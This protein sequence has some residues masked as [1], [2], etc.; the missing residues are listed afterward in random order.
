MF[1]I[2]TALSYVLP[3]KNHFYIGFIGLLTSFAISA[4]VW[5]VLIFFSVTERFEERW[6]EKIEL[7][8]GPVRIV[9]TEQY[10]KLPENQIDRLSS[11]KGYKTLRLN[12]SQLFEWDPLFDA[13]L[14][15]KE[16]ESLYTEITTGKSKRAVTQ[17][18]DALEK[19][20]ALIVGSETGVFDVSFSTEEENGQIRNASQYMLTIGRSLFF[21]PTDSLKTIW[22]AQ[23]LE[24]FMQMLLKVP[25]G[26]KKASEEL[27][28][29]FDASPILFSSKN[30]KSASLYTIAIEKS[31]PCIREQS[32]DS[33]T[34][35]IK[36]FISS[37]GIGEIIPQTKN[38]PMTSLPLE[39][40]PGVGY[41]VYL[42]QQMKAHGIELF[43]TGVL[44]QS[45]TNEKNGL[46]I[47]VMGF[48]DTGVLSIGGK[49]A[50]LSSQLVTSL[51]SSLPKS[52]DPF[53]SSSLTIFPSLNKPFDAQQA[54]QYAKN[55]LHLLPQNLQ[56]CFLIENYKEYKM[57]QELFTQL[58]SEKNLFR[59]IAIILL[60]AASTNIFS[61]L[62]ILVHTKTKEI[63]IMRALGASKKSIQAIF[64]FSGLFIGICGALVG[65]ILASITLMLLPEIM[66][67]L[68]ML[69]GHEVLQ[70]TIYGQM[71]RMTL[72]WTVFF[73]CIGV[74]GATSA[75]AGFLASLKALKLHISDSLRAG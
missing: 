74:T 40:I 71:E 48:F 60:S 62:F 2:S 57:T 45:A 32:P 27:L 17:L 21:L 14:Q 64:I 53:L 59:L 36:E 42:P 63:A 37:Y 50:I 19:E 22:T 33:A 30:K 15:S 16:Q 75:F 73:L 29:L 13:P 51:D 66:H 5:V 43:S 35:P 46:P 1:E 31:I 7:L 58:N 24:K 18:K 23:S 9:P 12:D 61:L 56:D 6:S 41:P 72:N 34:I 25:E 67:G 52:D 47:C 28:K 3:K 70:A 10:L 38:E 26:S 68:E 4:I 8:L 20:G 39:F 69:Q 54:M 49:V 44:S 11:A 55:A 65:T